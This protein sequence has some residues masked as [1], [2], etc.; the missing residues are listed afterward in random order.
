[1]KNRH[2]CLNRNESERKKRRK[3]EGNNEERN[4]EKGGEIKDEKW[5]GRTIRKTE[6]KTVEGKSRSK[7]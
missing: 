7:N 2:K 5:K 1:M 3:E 4:V 6:T